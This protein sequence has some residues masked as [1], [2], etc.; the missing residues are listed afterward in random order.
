[1]GYVFGYGYKTRTT[2]SNGNG[3]LNYVPVYDK[4]KLNLIME[5]EHAWQ[6]ASYSADILQFH[7]EMRHTERNHVQALMLIPELRKIQWW[8]F[9]ESKHR[10]RKPNQTKTPQN[11]QTV[12]TKETL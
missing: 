7:I 4:V 8:L 3:F 1:M 5:K 9:A 6:T 12:N 10:I 11:K 2:D